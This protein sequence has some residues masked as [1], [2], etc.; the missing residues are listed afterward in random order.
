[1][2]EKI[3]A[4]I[5]REIAIAKSSR[6]FGTLQRLVNSLYYNEVLTDFD[7]LCDLKTKITL[8]YMDW[9]DQNEKEG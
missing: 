2:N 9:R 8:A 4:I 1:M 7:A 3:T 6:E 5:E